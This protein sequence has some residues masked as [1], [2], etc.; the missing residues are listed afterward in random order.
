MGAP[1]RA[2][3]SVYALGL[4]L[5]TLGVLLAAAGLLVRPPLPCYAPR[6]LDP[7]APMPAYCGRSLAEIDDLTALYDSQRRGVR[8][9]IEAAEA[10]LNTRLLDMTARERV[11]RREAML[12]EPVSLREA[13]RELAAIDRELASLAR[14]RRLAA[15]P[16]WAPGA[17]L[18]AIGSTL[19]VG[20][21]LRRRVG[22]GGRIPKGF[23]RAVVVEET[24][25]SMTAE[26]AKMHLDGL[27]PRRTAALA[28]LW[29]QRPKICAY[30]QRRLPLTPA[31][32]LILERIVK[33]A[34]ADVKVVREIPLGE[35]WT[36]VA[37]ES[38]PCP[39]CG[40]ANRPAVTGRG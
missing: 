8:A 3:P 12:E 6:L 15:L 19:L 24:T 35:G 29:E 14:A 21:L 20:G 27:L 9:R 2:E 40:H 11:E 10:E 25:R 13:R 28:A 39:A 34:P 31:G 23:V 33:A 36:F 1:A 32:K 7:A 5:D 38:V 26:R 22:G 17:V 16:A 18:M 4:T 30:C 37:P